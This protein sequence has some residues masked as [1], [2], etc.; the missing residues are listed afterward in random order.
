MGVKT[1][2]PEKRN[3][4]KFVTSTAKSITVLWREKTSCYFQ[5]CVVEKG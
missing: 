4:K 2:F 5:I 1:L 3:C